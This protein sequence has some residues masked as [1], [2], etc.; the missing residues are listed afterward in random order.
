MIAFKS[1]PQYTRVVNGIRFQQNVKKPFL[2]TYFSE[3]SSFSDDY[4]KLNL[5]KLDFRIVVVPVTRIPRTRLNSD[6]RKEYKKYG[7]MSFSSNMAIPKHKNLIV[8]TTIYSNKID[9]DYKPQSYRQRAGKL[10]LN[11]LTDAFAVG[12][13]DMQKILVYSINIDKPVSPFMNRKSFALLRQLKSGEV[14]FDD[15]ILAV[16]SGSDVKYRLLIKDQKFKFAR[17]FQLFRSIKIHGAEEDIT[18]ENAMF[19]QEENIEIDPVTK[20]LLEKE[21]FND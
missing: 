8:D 16:I 6:N 21:T 4:P 15:M 2:L 7:L 12:E 10:I 14:F 5:M 17:I 18:D 3:N 1:L 13:G 9:Q 19:S 11:N 20:Y